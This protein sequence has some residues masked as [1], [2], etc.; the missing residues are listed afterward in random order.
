[1]CV[2]VH[3]CMCACVCVCMCVCVCVC[4]SVCVHVCVCVCVSVCV[5]HSPS[6]PAQR[7]VYREGLICTMACTDCRCSVIGRLQLL[8]G[9]SVSRENLDNCFPRIASLE[10]WA[11]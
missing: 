5:I 6:H 8:R 3:V 2:C 7:K 10:D 4:V 9:S 1:M 11:S